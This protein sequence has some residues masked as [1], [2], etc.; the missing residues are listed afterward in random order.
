MQENSETQPA[1]RAYRRRASSEK[2]QPKVGMAKSIM[3]ETQANKILKNY[4]DRRRILTVP[5]EIERAHPDKHFVFLNMN[6]LEKSGMW[7][8]GGYELLHA[9]DLPD[10]MVSKFQKSPDGYIH[11]N[12]M[13]LAYISKEEHEQR[14]VERQVARG[15]RRP[16][17]LFMKNES[18]KAFRPTANVTEEVKKFPAK[19]K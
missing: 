17:D 2:T 8:P 5:E 12:E 9:A 18:L 3:D 11:R 6:K 1:R 13:V 10:T 19:E 4:Y 7:H 14:E 15:R 16:E